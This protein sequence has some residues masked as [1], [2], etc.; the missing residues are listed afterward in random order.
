MIKYDLKNWK[1]S[2]WARVHQDIHDKP[3]KLDLKKNGR[4]L[5]K[6]EKFE[7]VL[8]IEVFKKVVKYYLKN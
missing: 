1:I 3:E 5:L 7:C 2:S 8:K 6:N 4:F